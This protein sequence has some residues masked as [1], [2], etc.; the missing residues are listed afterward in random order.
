MG[1]SVTCVHARTWNLSCVPVSALI[2][3]EDQ[4]H[5]GGFEMWVGDED[6]NTQLETLSETVVK[7]N[8][9]TSCFGTDD[10]F[11]TFLAVSVQVCTHDFISSFRNLLR[12]SASTK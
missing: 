7:T 6:V 10:G 5:V 3:T 8:R 9:E 11:L 4:G 1:V 12:D 2:A